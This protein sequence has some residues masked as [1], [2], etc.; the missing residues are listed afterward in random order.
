MRILG[1][2]TYDTSKHPRMGVI[3]DG[4]R[5]HGNTVI[6]ANL[7][8]GLSTAERVKMLERPWQVYRL[9]VRLLC[10]WGKLLVRTVQVRQGGSIDAVIVGY[11]GHFD[12]LWARLLFPRTTI[13]LDLLIFASDTA[14]DRGVTASIRLKALRLLDVVACR[15]ADIVLVDTEEHAGRVP[16][17]AARKVEVVPVG[18]SE[19]WF[20][21]AATDRIDADRPLRVAF[22]GL[23]T[24]LQGAPVV[25]EAIAMLAECEDIEFTMIGTGQDYSLSRSLAA[26]NTMVTWTDWVDSDELPGVIAGHDVCLGVFGTTAKAQRVVPNKVYQGAAAGCAIVTSDTA[27]QRRALRDAAIFVR[28][29]DPG[30]L[31]DALRVL[32]SDRGMTL[33][34]RKASIQ[35]SSSSFAPAVV[36]NGLRTVL[37]ARVDSSHS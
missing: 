4:L 13:A 24:P 19:H 6:E 18:A 25:A 21:A 30:A 36:V 35:L 15:S 32:A 17:A 26:P 33:S 8:L 12:V 7:P 37:S 28:A 14:E 20:S 9:A 22:F 16:L 2:G 5:A 11:M 1:F 3:L 23:Y 31:A 34:R 29:G 10:R 27:P